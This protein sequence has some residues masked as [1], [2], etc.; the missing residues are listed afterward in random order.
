M[1]KL[2]HC[3][4]CNGTPQT[5]IKTDGFR[6]FCPN[7]GMTT[8]VLPVQELAEKEWNMY[9]YNADNHVEK[10]VERSYTDIQKAQLDLA[11]EI[12]AEKNKKITTK[13]VIKKR[14]VKD[15]G[16]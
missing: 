1:P 6:V 7:C 5:E 13:R 15:D 3:S 10:A 9:Q 8:G 16:K 11:K 14:K 2:K 4:L 12:I